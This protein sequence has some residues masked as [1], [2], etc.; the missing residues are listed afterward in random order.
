M[1]EFTT[2]TP[3]DQVEQPVAKPVRVAPVPMSAP[4]PVAAVAPDPLVA[5]MQTMRSGAAPIAAAAPAM[6][7]LPPPP[8]IQPGEA[9]VNY[10]R[11]LSEHY[12][13]VDQMKMDAVKE[14]EKTA[15]EA[16]APVKK[17]DLG[18][19]DINRITEL[20]DSLGA[21]TRLME[22]FKPNYGGYKVKFAGNIANTI[23]S[24]FGGDNEAQAEWWKAYDANDNISRA[25]TYGATLTPGET[26]AWERTTVDISMTPQMIERRMKE[27][28]ALIEAKRKT[29][30][31][32]LG[33]ANFNVE[34]FQTA[35]TNFSPA[36]VVAPPVAALKE[37][38][39]TTFKNG[40]QWILKNGKPEKVN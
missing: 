11:R 10:K 4:A 35:P 36:P 18:S 28:A 1:A 23:A 14:A 8:K 22:T 32:N 21:Q 13:R 33:K 9:P 20:D 6:P 34:N 30:I 27:R 24:T 25:A 38:H 12:Q 3:I 40:Q 5:A 39:V 17:R 15:R 16:A 31:E 19:T 29:T 2:F 37:G 7:A 26:A